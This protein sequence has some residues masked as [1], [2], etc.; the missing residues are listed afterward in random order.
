MAVNTQLMPAKGMTLPFVSYGG[1][2]LISLALG[3]GFLVALT[4]KRPRTVAAQ[5]EAPRHRAGHRRRGDAVTVF[6]PTILLCARR[7]RRPPVPGREPRPRAARP[8]LRVALATDARGSTLSRP[9]SRPREVVTIAS[10]TPVRPVAAGQGARRHP[11]AR[12]RLR[13]RRQRDPADQPGRHRGLRRLPDRAAGARRPDPARADGAARAERRDGPG[14]RLPGAGRPTIATG[15]KKS[16]G[17]PDNA[18]QGAARPYRQPAPPGGDRGGEGPVSGLRRRHVLRLLVF[19]GSQ[20]AR[21]MGEVVPEA[22]ARL[23]AACARPP[24]P[25]PAGPAPRT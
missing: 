6:T 8:R 16:R 4:R 10:A 19:G 21:V 15:F 2:S 24:A 14:Q 3:T 7:H 23:P 9:S 1:S 13:R 12:P 17:V 5:P 18:R 25:R 11:D 22:I 20:G